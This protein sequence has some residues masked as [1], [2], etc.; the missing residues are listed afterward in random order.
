MS[1]SKENL[2]SPRRR[3][4]MRSLAGHTA[5]YGLG[6]AL[7]ALGGFILIPLYTHNFVPSQYGLLELLNRIADVLLLFV[8]MGTRQAYIRFYFDDESD[9]WHRTV[10]ATT[11]LFAL[12][13]ALVIIPIA[14]LAAALAPSQFWGDENAGRL[15][16]LIALWIPFEIIFTVSLAY[17]QVSMRSLL[18]VLVNAIRLAGFISLNVWLV[19]FK[20]FGIDG[21]FLSQ[22]IIV[23]GIALTFLV[24]LIRWTRLSFSLDLL[25]KL[26][27][28]GAP[29]IPSAILWYVA[30][31]AD[32][33]FIASFQSMTDLGIYSLAL[34]LGSVA[35]ALFMQPFQ[36][37]WS[38]FIFSTYES[39]DGPSRIGKAF[40]AFT[41]F[42]AYLVLGISVLAPVVLPYLSDASYWD[43]AL[44]IPIIATAQLLYGMSCLIDAG[45][46]IA[47]KTNYKPIIFGLT[48]LVSILAQ[49]L[50]T[51]RFSI[52]G[53][54]CAICITF[55]FLFVIN[56]H[57][58][59]RH[60]RLTLVPADFLAIAVAASASLFIFEWLYNPSA[61]S[62]GA[63]GA[64]LI[65]AFTYPLFLMLLRPSAANHYIRRLASTHE[66]T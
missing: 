24:F 8:F 50:L 16:L 3:L 9:E 7:T 2:A 22:L 30:A 62:L 44:V 42:G 25:K 6:S 64:V 39:S 27:R 26:V 45:I 40:T 15:I 52:V 61:G 63:I 34:K 59:D 56:K 48:A 60:Y 19:Y 14:I 54:A 33:F 49:F 51:S 58:S 46:L 43:A 21:V 55:G 13:S 28:F 32:R 11:L 12:A 38:P 57:Y 5:V 36:K 66:D 18:Y 29:Y 35:L 17:L 37:V 31:N 20:G 1:D 53:A 65:P 41:A 47:K 10:T 23:A 4:N